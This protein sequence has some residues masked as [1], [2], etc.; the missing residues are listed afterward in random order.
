MTRPAVSVLA[1]R[2]E[3]CWHSPDP[4]VNVLMGPMTMLLWSLSSQQQMWSQ[5]QG[6]LSRSPLLPP[7]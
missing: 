5:A 6:L 4:Q 2:K 1:A 3:A 7:L